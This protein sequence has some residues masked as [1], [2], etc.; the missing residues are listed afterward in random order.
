MAIAAVEVA[1]PEGAQAEVTVLTAATVMQVVALAAAAQQRLA[2][3][4]T[5]KAVEQEQEVPEQTHVEAWD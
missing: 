2:A 3:V 4:G 5:S 1:M